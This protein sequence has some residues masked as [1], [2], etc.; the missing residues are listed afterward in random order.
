MKNY[1]GDFNPNGHD[2]DDEILEGEIADAG[3]TDFDDLDYTEFDDAGL[4]EFDDL[5]D[6]PEGA[7]DDRINRVLD[8]LAELRR[9]MSPSERRQAG[10]PSYD[11]YRGGNTPGEVALYNEISRLRDELA[12]LQHS[13]SMHYELNRMKEELEK[14]N[15]Q[16]ED[17]LRSEIRN[18]RGADKAVYAEPAQAEP[19]PA[20]AADGV[21]ALVKANESLA[22]CVKS[23]GD[24]LDADM[25]DLRRIVADA[26]VRRETGDGAKER[27]CA[28]E[29]HKCRGRRQASRGGGRH[30][31]HA[32][33][34]RDKTD[35]R[36]TPARRLRKGA[37]SART[38]RQSD[39]GE[40][41]R[42]FFGVRHGRKAGRAPQAGKRDNRERGL[43]YRR[44][45]REV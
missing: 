2:A 12:K 17:K 25:T 11:S 34:S 7:D 4:D 9:S 5:D 19:K 40:I 31:N 18:M 41:R 26:A 42:I 37:Q 33:L 27:P 3:D 36:Q 24:K 1:N 14:E 35:A 29:A 43:L 15:K 13:Q 20:A 6:L 8:E 23:L 22:E 30:R 21:D 32:P 10:A 44:R 16:N 38:V 39:R 45:G 28:R